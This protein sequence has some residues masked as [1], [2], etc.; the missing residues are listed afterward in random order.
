MEELQSVCTILNVAVL[1]ITESKLDETIPSNIVML[2]GYYEPIRR[3]R[4]LNGRHGGGCLMY[5]SENLTY[6][7][8]TELQSDYFEHLWADIKI[9]SHSFS[10]TCLYR[11]PKES[12]IDHEL[13]FKY[14]RANLIYSV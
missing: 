6:K 1:C 7:Q 11:P 10:V 8:K 3:D 5:I 2:Q 12:S 4:A 14:V 13:F 9:G